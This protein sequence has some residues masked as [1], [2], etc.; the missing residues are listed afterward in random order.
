MISNKTKRRIHNKSES[1]KL[2]KTAKY[3]VFCNCV[4]IHLTKRKRR[5]IPITLSLIPLTQMELKET[6]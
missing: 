5:P 4:F 6:R 3:L 2:L 1:G